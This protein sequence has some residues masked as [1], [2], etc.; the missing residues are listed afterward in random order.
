MPAPPPSAYGW[1]RG[2]A[3]SCFAGQSRNGL[4]RR[5][6]CFSLED[7]FL[8]QTTYLG[9]PGRGTSHAC[10]YETMGE[11]PGVFRMT[12]LTNFPYRKIARI[13]GDRIT[14]HLINESVAVSQRWLLG[15]TI[16]ERAG[17]DRLELYH[18]G[19]SAQS[20][21]ITLHRVSED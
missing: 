9:F 14:I 12:C 20:P 10:R 19:G 7:G 13:D 4:Q 15:D 16:L 2:L 5:R 6:E 21:P 8:V 11:D 3:G 17:P 1:A 18:E